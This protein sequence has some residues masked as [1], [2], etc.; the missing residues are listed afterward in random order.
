M[1]IKLHD[2]LGEELYMKIRSKFSDFDLI[3]KMK[4][5]EVI[6]IDETKLKSK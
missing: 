5:K 2:V 1:N 4:T 3:K 6:K